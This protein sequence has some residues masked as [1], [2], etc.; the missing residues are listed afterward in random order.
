MIVNSVEMKFIENKITSFSPHFSNKTTS[1]AKKITVT[2][3][4]TSLKK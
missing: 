1:V 3:L 2:N 4:I